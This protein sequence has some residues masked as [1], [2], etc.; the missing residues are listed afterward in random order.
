MSLAA[1]QAVYLPVQTVR[2]PSI[3]RQRQPA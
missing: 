1:Q 3:H 2:S